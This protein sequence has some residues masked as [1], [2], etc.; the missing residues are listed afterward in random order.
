[1]DGDDEMMVHKFMEEEADV[2]ADDVEE[3]AAPRHGGMK[4]G[5]KKSKPR[6]RM[7]GHAMLYTD[8]FTDETSYYAKNFRMRYRMHKEVFRK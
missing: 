5:Q 3:A 2:I 8:Y 1:M 7:E 6:Q 4:F